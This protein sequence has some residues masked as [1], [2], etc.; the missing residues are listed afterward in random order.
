M[1]IVV[2][3]ISVFIHVLSAMFWLG[4]ML[5][6]AMVLVP[7]FRDKILAEHRGLFFAKMG[8]IFSNISWILFLVLITTGYI[9][10]L[11]RGYS[12][13]DLLDYKFWHSLFGYNFAHKMV[14]FG[15]MLMI[16][17]IHDFWLGPHTTELM[18]REPNAKR[19]QSYRRA[20]SMLGRLNLLLGLIIIYYAISLVRG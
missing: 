6:T 12:W 19:T 13:N 17:G 7:T 8:K 11:A 5:F 16:S 18:N 9:Q 1:S 4:G 20:T 10:L 2:Y 15:I 14:F 3:K